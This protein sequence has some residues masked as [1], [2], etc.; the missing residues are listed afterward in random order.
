MN[1]RKGNELKK[2]DSADLMYPYG[3]SLWVDKAYM[4]ACGG[5]PPLHLTLDPVSLAD[6]PAYTPPSAPYCK[7]P[8]VPILVD[9]RTGSQ[10]F[11][12]I[13]PCALSVADSNRIPVDAYEQSAFIPNDPSTIAFRRQL[14]LLQTLPFA[15][16]ILML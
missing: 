6:S 11:T 1:V 14:F 2:K 4:M 7:V 13:H 9:G 5:H 10:T 3:H 12:C 15:W 16:A 8:A